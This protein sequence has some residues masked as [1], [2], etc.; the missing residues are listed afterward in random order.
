MVFFSIFL[1]QWA[2]IVSEDHVVDDCC[3]TQNQLKQLCVLVCQHHHQML[4]GAGNAYLAPHM[5]L[6]ARRRDP[7]QSG[8]C[9]G[10]R[11][12]HC[13]EVQQPSSALAS[14]TLV[15]NR[16]EGIIHSSRRTAMKDR[17][18]SSSHV[19]LGPAGSTSEKAS[20]ELLSEDELL[21]LADLGVQVNGLGK[22][23]H[24]LRAIHLYPMAHSVMLDREK[25][26]QLQRNVWASSMSKK[27]KLLIMLALL[28]WAASISQNIEFALNHVTDVFAAVVE[29]EVDGWSLCSDQPLFFPTEESRE[30][31][32]VQKETKRNALLCQVAFSLALCVFSWMPNTLWMATELGKNLRQALSEA[33]SENTCV[34][35]RGA[36]FVDVW[37]KLVSS[38]EST[39]KASVVD[40][41]LHSDGSTD[42]TSIAASRGSKLLSP[43]PLSR[44]PASES[45]RIGKEKLKPVL[46]HRPQKGKAVS[47]LNSLVACSSGFSPDGGSLV[48]DHRQTNICDTRHLGNTLT[49]DSSLVLYPPEGL[50]SIPLAASSEKPEKLTLTRRRCPSLPLEVTH[51]Q[52]SLSA[53]E[54]HSVGA[55]DDTTSGASALVKNVGQE[56]KPKIRSPSPK[57]S[58]GDSNTRLLH[59][60]SNEVRPGPLRPLHPNVNNYE[61]T[62]HR[63]LAPSLHVP[64]HESKSEQT[65][66]YVS[67]A[68]KDH[69]RSRPHKPQS[70]GALK[71]GPHLS[72]VAHEPLPVDLPPFAS[73]PKLPP[74]GHPSCN[75]VAWDYSTQKMHPLQM[76]LSFE[77]FSGKS[78]EAT[79]GDHSGHSRHH[80]CE[81]NAEEK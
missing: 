67:T 21:L 64:P 2:T 57:P 55:L 20:E 50:R 62:K 4:K 47:S 26:M 42:L 53:I 73:L 9:S 58:L 35:W 37:K 70:T 10:R 23:T 52:T 16:E 60:Q 11:S 81:T 77:A 8:H 48:F 78:S 39:R 72:P 69:L 43:L 80:K 65:A 71:K 34:P 38:N 28:L 25:A 3:V 61:I 32:N 5:D 33:K 31:A 49:S 36:L 79:K 18:G 12:L 63:K 17:P 74:Q 46:V 14:S 66:T 27:I 1:R 44:I 56:D 22:L 76:D 51:C 68:V 41:T 19:D 45:N 13:V 30:M 24:I 40:T 59:S 75:T 15:M 6:S 54:G 7:H 29:N